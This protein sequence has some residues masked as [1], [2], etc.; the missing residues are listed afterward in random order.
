MENLRLN[1][2]AKSTKVQKKINSEAT[3]VHYMTKFDNRRLL[4]LSI[5]YLFRSFS[6]EFVF[7]VW[8]ICDGSI[9]A[10]LDSC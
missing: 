8:M 4:C 6:Q 1:K 7:I 3:I 5:S 9:C 2:K 10:Q